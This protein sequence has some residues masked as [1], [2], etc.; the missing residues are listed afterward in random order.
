MSETLFTSPSAELLVFGDAFTFQDGLAS[1][2]AR[3]L[4]YFGRSILLDQGKE[5]WIVRR[6]NVYEP[7]IA[8]LYLPNQEIAAT[9]MYDTEQ[10]LTDVFCTN[11]T[12]LYV[13]EPLC[14]SVTFEE[15]VRQ[16]GIHAIQLKKDLAT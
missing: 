10:G 8:D 16:A 4:Y 6:F 15:A 3:K 9:L 2:E 5:P 14:K 13:E 7:I 1:E 12:D 11:G